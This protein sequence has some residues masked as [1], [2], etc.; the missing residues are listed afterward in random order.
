LTVL[1][2]VTTKDLRCIANTTKQTILRGVPPAVH[3][4]KAAVSVFCKAHEGESGLLSVPSQVN[5]R[6][7]PERRGT[8]NR[9]GRNRMAADGLADKQKAPP[10]D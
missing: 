3:P 10:K 1:P 5:G 7:D 8:N 9:E 6:R 4:E 2:K